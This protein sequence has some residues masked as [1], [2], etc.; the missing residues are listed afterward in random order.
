MSSDPRHAIINDQPCTPFPEPEP[1]TKVWTKKLIQKLLDE[2]S[3]AVERALLAIH[4]RQTPQEQ[5]GQATLEDNGIGFNAFDAF[6]LSSFTE[7]IKRSTYPKGKRLSPKQLTVA[8]K[9][10][11]KYAGQ[12]LQIVAI[13]GHKVG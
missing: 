5:N 4:D 3:E 7:H 8:R 11:R 12:L 6:I 10:I 13:K 2:N 1:E 9:K